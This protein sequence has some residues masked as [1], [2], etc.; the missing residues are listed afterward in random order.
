MGD[1]LVVE[2]SL[3]MDQMNHLVNDRDLVLTVE[4]ADDAEKE[5]AKEESGKDKQLLKPN[6]SPLLEVSE[7]PSSNEPLATSEVTTPNASTDLK[8]K[9]DS[10]QELQGGYLEIDNSKSV[11]EESKETT[12]SD[13]DG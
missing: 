5:E 7:S 6:D 3:E 1:R 2:E 4:S 11:M 13:D 12:K 8:E 9:R 10:Q